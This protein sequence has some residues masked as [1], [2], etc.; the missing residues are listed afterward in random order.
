MKVLNQKLI[1]DIGLDIVAKI[2]VQALYD[3]LVTDGENSHSVSEWLISAFSNQTTNMPVAQVAKK[4][5]SK[6]SRKGRQ[7]NAN[8]NISLNHPNLLGLPTISH[9][10]VN[11]YP[12]PFSLVEYS[13]NIALDAWLLSHEHSLASVWPNKT[14][15]SAS[16]S[17]LSLH[18][19][20]ILRL[21]PSLNANSKQ[22]VLKVY[23]QAT[24]IKYE[25]PVIRVR[26]RE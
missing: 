14:N 12:T 19:A 2:I 8:I 17:K 15:C 24:N 20:E 7:A 3:T 13:Y 25:P 26:T 6:I 9:S 10:A 23:C 5:A 1:P 22:S 16:R 18:P 4:K 11:P 21:N